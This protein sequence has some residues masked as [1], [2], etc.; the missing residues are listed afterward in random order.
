MVT[1]QDLRNLG[2]NGLTDVLDLRPDVLVPEPPRNLAELAARLSHP[3]SL[4]AAMRSFSLPVLQ[5]AEALAAIGP[6]AHRDDLDRL[7]GVTDDDRRA[8]VD[9]IL[10]VLARLLMLG[11][12]A[13]QDGDGAPDAY[14]GVE[15]RGRLRLDPQVAELW[16]RPLGLQ[17][18]LA[19]L[20]PARTA[21]DLRSVLRALGERPPNRK[22]DLVERLLAVLGD[23]V[24]V[25][26]IVERAPVRVAERLRQIAL[27]A[28]AGPAYGGLSSLGRDP[29]QW[30]IDRMLLVRTGW[31]GQLVMPA[32]VALAL[33][34]P[35]WRAPFDAEAPAVGW[36][37]SADELI[38]RESAAA[39]AHA[40]RT[41]TAV[42][43]QV[44]STPITLLKSG[45]IGVREL[46]RV[47]KLAGCSAAEV[48][49][50][51]ALALWAE[52]IGLDG[53]R[54]T[55]TVQ[56]DVW[57][58]ATPAEQL[59]TLVRH[60]VALP[61]CILQAP[62]AAW[63]PESDPGVTSLRVQ[64]LVLLSN[65]PGQAPASVEALAD[66]ALWQVPF[67]HSES[68]L[69][70]IFDAFTDFAAADEQDGL[71][72]QDPRS[73][74]SARAR[75][76]TVA[77]T[78]ALLDEAAWLGLTGAGALSR[79][80]T[81]VIGGEDIV[82]AQ[83]GLGEVQQTARLQADLTAVVLGHPSPRLAGVLDE[84]A[85]KES[86]SVAATWRFSPQSVRRAMDAGHDRV[87][88]EQMLASIAEDDVPQPLAYLVADVDR[89]HGLLRVGDVGGYLRCEDEALLGEILADRSLRRLRLRRIA[90]TVLGAAEPVPVVLGALR[91][92]GYLPVAEDET[93][94]AL[95]ERQE[96]LRVPAV[97]DAPPGP[98]EV[99]P[100]AASEAVDAH[101]AAL[102][103]LAAPDGTD[104]LLPDP[105]FP[106]DLRTGGYD[107]DDAL[108]D[109]VIDM[110][111]F[112]QMMRRRDE[113]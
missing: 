11:V 50:C 68:V 103:L 35:G 13:V 31:Y 19:D 75:T 53:D 101:A 108:D 36:M 15:V 22:A 102:A 5:V 112:E 72:G 3:F 30:A 81:A 51:L 82:A 94:T 20:A 79:S 23:P 89:R 47:A 52:M 95:V 62:E 41:F 43:Q 17:D 78:G 61:E 12:P 83:T 40:L 111:A 109:N 42:L 25:S 70:R 105:L 99:D 39:G 49:L 87:T 85:D 32:E 100:P 48:R 96:S 59:A 21:D 46:R 4:T 54:V 107:P 2:E 26:R 84:L 14:E 65:N 10:M 67:C 73:A 37:P 104:H 57:L 76:A 63:F 33:R 97:P 27:G 34:G 71:D 106:D 7:L 93:G 24:T 58:A 60:W 113:G 28:A 44:G 66:W 98:A 86:R 90:P 91:R 45:G 38:Q 16:S 9:H 18:C 77:L 64:L 92:A 29:L 6:H 80:G 110:A 8:V 88:I 56:L 69:E 55:P 74:S 1:T